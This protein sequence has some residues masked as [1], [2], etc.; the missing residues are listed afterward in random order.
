MAVSDHAGPDAISRIRDLVHKF[1]GIWYRAHIRER[2]KYISEILGEWRAEL[3]W[4]IT[5]LRPK[6]KL[7]KLQSENTKSR[8]ELSQHHALNSSQIY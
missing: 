6:P 5:T 8:I 3:P 1:D 4:A 2:I 7:P